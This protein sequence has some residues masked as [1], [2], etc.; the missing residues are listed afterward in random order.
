MMLPSGPTM[1]PSKS[2][3][4]PT[5]GTGLCLDNLEA[6]RA[7][8]L[9]LQQV[10]TAH[11][12]YQAALSA[13]CMASCVR[14]RPQL[15]SCLHRSYWNGAQALIPPY[16]GLVQAELPDH[17]R[18]AQQLHMVCKQLRPYLLGDDQVPIGLASGI[19]STCLPR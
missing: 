7:A 18:S 11:A 14:K 15:S 1:Q 2:Q 8:C 10:E 17:V 6:P 13:S 19:A 5:K 3:A 4:Q 9:V 12:L 16:Y